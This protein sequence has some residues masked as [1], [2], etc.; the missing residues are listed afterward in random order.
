MFLIH[1][2]DSEIWDATGH[3]GTFQMPLMLQWTFN[4]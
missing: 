2:M 3:Y 1:P 4:R